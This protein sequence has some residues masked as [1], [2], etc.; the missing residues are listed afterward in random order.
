VIT[1]LSNQSVLD[2]AIQ[3]DG[4]VLAAF[5]WAIAN[6]ISITEELEPGQKLTSQVS[7]F[8]NDDVARYFGGKK[9]MIATAMINE[10][11][12]NPPV[13]IG[14]MIIETNFIVQ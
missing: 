13:G 1:V 4:N 5:E 14:S 9:Q 8:R 10:S 11:E 3:E 12:I 2:I 7:V 6:G